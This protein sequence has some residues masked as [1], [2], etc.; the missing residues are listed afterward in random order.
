MLVNVDRLKE[1]IT[2]LSDAIEKYENNYLNYYKEIEQLKLYW[3]SN[4]VNSFFKVIDLEKKDTSS[5]YYD[6][7]EYK[8]IYSYIAKKFSYFGNCIIFNLEYYDKLINDFNNYLDEQKKIIS[9]YQNLD[10]SFCNDESDKIKK[11]YNILKNNLFVI[12]D[13]KS[14]VKT[15]LNKIETIE[16]SIKY[17][18]SQIN[19][20]FLKNSD[21]NL[22]KDIDNNEFKINID[23][24][25]TIFNKLDFY[26]KEEDIIFEEIKDI[27]NI[28]IN[29]Y[30]TNN[31][32]YF[33]ELKLHILNNI[34]TISYNHK[35][36]LNFINEKLNSYKK[37]NHIINNATDSLRG[38]V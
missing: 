23:L 9:Y 3:S 34:K 11:Q 25:E 8:N 26:I 6:L 10:L 33:E 37:I 12:I 38:M 14:N 36:N 16:K 21:F 31:K 27:F 1:T 28:F 4:N 35:N 29:C 20:S 5:L 13:I 17:K 15:K 19:V 18:I 2:K 30:D 7:I 24:F 22:F 32:N